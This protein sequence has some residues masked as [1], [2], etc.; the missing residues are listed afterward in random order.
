[1]MSLL[2]DDYNDLDTSTE[3]ERPEDA[4]NTTQALI[5][6]ATPRHLDEFSS[7]HKGEG[8]QRYKDD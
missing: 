8:Y 3:I 7:N 1:M 4:Q 2:R 5:P 6:D